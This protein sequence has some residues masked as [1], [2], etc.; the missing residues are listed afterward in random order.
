MKN[1]TLLIFTLLM[2]AGWHT[3]IY[4]GPNKYKDIKKSQKKE[5]DKKDALEAEKKSKEERE[6]K[7][8]E[9]KKAKYDRNLAAFNNREKIT[10]TTQSPSVKKKYVEADTKLKD[11]FDKK[12]TQQKIESWKKKAELEKDPF[13]NLDTDLFSPAK[14]KIKSAEKQNNVDMKKEAKK[15]GEDKKQQEK[16]TTRIKRRI[17]L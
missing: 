15:K 6:K 10:S 14:T 11:P 3:S 9:A 8:A 12:A 16:K 5:Q 17:L 7:E 4:N 13:A 2:Y 1:N